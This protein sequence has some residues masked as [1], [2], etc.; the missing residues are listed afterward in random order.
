MKSPYQVAKELNIKPQTVYKRL[1]SEFITEFANHITSAKGNKYML[2]DVAEAALKALF[3]PSVIPGE[4]AENKPDIPPDISQVIS[5]NAFLRDR[6]I[7]L[8]GEIH[9]ERVHSR[10]QADKMA[11]LAADMAELT[12]N[13]QILLGMTQKQTEQGLDVAPPG[14]QPTEEQTPRP[15]LLKRLFARL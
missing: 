11:A 4:Q 2:D 7:A 3:I 15:G 10:S 9:T 6:V 14:P 8:E 13:N 12:R 1:T 5:E